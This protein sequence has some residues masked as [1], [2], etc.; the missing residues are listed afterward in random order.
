MNKTEL[1]SKISRDTYLTK[2]VVERVLKS[3]F[4]TVISEVSSGKSVKLIDFGIFK[5]IKKKRRAGWDVKTGKSVEK[6]EKYF[7]KFYPG[8]LFRDSVAEGL[9][10]ELWE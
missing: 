6:P 9:S 3:F 7:P 2:D 4:A 1:I 8:K 10:G 5:A